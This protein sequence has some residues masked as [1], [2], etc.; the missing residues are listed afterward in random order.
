MTAART[1]ESVIGAEVERFDALAAEWW[2]PDG[3]MAPLHALQPARLA[4]VRERLGRH[5]GR[6]AR[7]LKPFAGLRLLDLG[8]GAGLL[9]EPLARLGASVTAVDAAERS[10][11]AA[12]AHAGAA[13]LA[14]D[15]RQ[16]AAEDLVAA[17][18]QFDAVLS[19]EVVEHVH[20]PDAFVA[21]AVAL[22]RPGGA[23]VLSTLNR[24]LRSLLL[25]VV[26]A[27][28]VLRLVPRGTHDWR[29]FVRP[30]EMGLWLERAGARLEDVTGL[31]FDPLARA[32]RLGR[33]ARVNY[34]AFAT[35]S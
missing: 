28:Y 4:Y 11:A 27:E 23:L 3:P 15:Y 13:G 18:E 12:R 35:R 19:L 29:R 20:A 30:A 21:A 17:G 8:C 24:N 6:D 34:L 5:F 16:A 10:V 14:I 7:D 1:A 31:E 22:T 25:G 32:W 2:D 33:D 26:A 9:S